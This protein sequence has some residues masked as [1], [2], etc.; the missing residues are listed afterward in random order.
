M[1]TETIARL[2]ES[3][4][5]APSVSPGLAAG[6]LPTFE[7]VVAVTSATAAVMTTVGTYE[8]ARLA[9][10]ADL[11]RRGLNVCFSHEGIA[12]A[13]VSFADHRLRLPP[14][15]EFRDHAGTIRH[16]A[17]LTAQTD[18]WPLECLALSGLPNSLPPEAAE[19]GIVLTPPARPT[20]RQSID[21]QAIPHLLAH[22]AA[23]R[24]PMSVVLGNAGCL[25]C[26]DGV[27]EDVSK[28]G[29]LIFLRLERT[30]LSFDPALIGSWHVRSA[31]GDE[32][33]RV[34][35]ARCA[36]GR[37]Q[38]FMTVGPRD[39]ANVATLWNAILGSL[40]H[41]GPSQL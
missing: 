40:P 35:E 7:S 20:P 3:G 36:D 18:T 27:I 37:R 13:T 19:S 15:I 4:H 6:Y 34:L 24:L 31:E 29:D 5:R 22:L 17:Y 21:R 26:D 30:T 10:K 8:S 23:L 1:S 11:G 14:A 41:S 28:T 16:T 2:L 12:E 9:R 38:F 32:T 33:R 39:C 25:H